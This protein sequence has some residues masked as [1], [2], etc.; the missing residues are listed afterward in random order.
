M[1]R[2]E[3]EIRNDRELVK[4]IEQGEICRIALCEDNI[5]YIVPMN[6]GL[7]DN[8]IYFHS[9]KKG[10]KI[11]IIKKNN[12][13]CFEIEID[14]KIVTAEKACNWGM[15]Y[16]SI[17]GYGYIEEVSDVKEKKNALL[18]LMRQYDKKNQDW[19][20]NTDSFEKTLVLRLKIAQMSGK[21]SGY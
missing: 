1:R 11:D 12:Y 6:Y 18:S 20:F 3:K 14:T 5:P 13:A 10:K 21:K 9:A 8:N 15:S 4:I 16:K 7:I 19:T 2:K 17:I